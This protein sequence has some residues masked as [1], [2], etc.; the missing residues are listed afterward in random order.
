[1]LFICETDLKMVR[2]IIGDLKFST[3]TKTVHLIMNV[4]LLKSV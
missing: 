1:M 2:E 4:A 3:S